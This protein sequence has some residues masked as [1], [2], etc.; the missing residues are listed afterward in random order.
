MIFM[1]IFSTNSVTL[2]TNTEVVL[3]F[4]IWLLFNSNNG[5][6]YYFLKNKS[7]YNVFAVFP[8][9]YDLSWESALAKTATTFILI[10]GVL[11]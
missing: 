5:N 3:S 11:K 6:F 4:H 2:I 1:P 10:T 7:N 8:Q 9:L